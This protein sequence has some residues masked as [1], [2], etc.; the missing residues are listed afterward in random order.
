MPGSDL[1]ANAETIRA[2]DR[3]HT[4]LDLAS[5]DAKRANG[6]VW[7]AATIADMPWLGEI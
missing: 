2:C 7:P 3:S 6:P 1:C 4:N 5:R